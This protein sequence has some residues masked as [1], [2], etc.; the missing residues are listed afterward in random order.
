MLRSLSVS[1]I[2][3]TLGVRPHFSPFP[4][5]TMAKRKSSKSSPAPSDG[6]QLVDRS[7]LAAPWS[8]FCI[9]QPFSDIVHYFAKENI[10]S[11][12]SAAVVPLLNTLRPLL[13]RF[14]SI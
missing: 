5:T 11:S 13:V 1:L 14:L 6:F 2:G 7:S 12:D 4:S 9:Y 8:F 10:S 3:E